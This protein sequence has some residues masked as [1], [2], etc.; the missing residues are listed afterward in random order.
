[1]RSWM[2]CVY[3]MGGINIVSWYVDNFVIGGDFWDSGMVNVVVSIFLGGEYYELY[4]D[5]LDLLVVY[6]KSLKIG[7]LIKRSIF[8]IF[9]FFY[10]YM[11]FWF[12]WGQFYCS[13]E[14]Y[15]SF[16]CFIV[17]YFCD[18]KKVYNLLYCYF[19]D[20]FEDEVYYLECYFGNEYVD[21]MGLDNY[22]D[23]Y[24]DNDLSFFIKCLNMFV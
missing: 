14:E 10:E 9:W 18:V 8:I 13:F 12:W 19:L 23:V 17:Y 7:I 3:K 5:K 4:K 15:K 22:Y 6:F 11:G 1:M 16:W 24:F 21:I 2:I 20:I